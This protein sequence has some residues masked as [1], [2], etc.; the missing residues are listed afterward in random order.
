MVATDSANI[1]YAAVQYSGSSGGI[2]TNEI[3]IPGGANRLWVCGYYA[4]EEAFL[5]NVL[6]SKAEF[7]TLAEQKENLGECYIDGSEIDLSSNVV[8]GFIP[9]SDKFKTGDTL[10]FS[11]SANYSYSYAPVNS[12]KSYKVTLIESS[13]YAR[14]WLFFTNNNLVIRQALW[15]GSQPLTSLPKTGYVTAPDASTRLY[16][17][18]F[19]GTSQ[20][21][22]KNVRLLNAT[23]VSAATAITKIKKENNVQHYK[24]INTVDL[25]AHTL[26]NK[27][28]SVDDV[29]QTL[30]FNDHTNY[31]AAFINGV[32]PGE[33]YKVTVNEASNYGK[34]WVYFTSDSDDPK[35]IERVFEP[36]GKGGERSEVVLV[37]SGASR[38]YIVS[39]TNTEKNYLRH[40]YIN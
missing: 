15:L 9:S 1:V 22:L 28:P 29:C 2:Q 7:Y 30:E 19:Y 24:I 23:K 25:S 36:S 11:S 34:Y 39:Y 13:N 26:P 40:I 14:H 10:T 21:Y 5:T 12:G 33:Y 8:T 31:S 6:I 17:V 18:S 3:T 32:R 38:M 20:A 37:P 4:S 27:I 35:V 16:I